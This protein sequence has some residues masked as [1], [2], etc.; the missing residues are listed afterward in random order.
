MEEEMKK[1]ELFN[2]IKKVKGAINQK[3]VLGS[4][5]GKVETFTYSQPPYTHQN[6]N[7]SK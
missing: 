1:M 6:K 5:G 7:S 3:A 4:L 2:L